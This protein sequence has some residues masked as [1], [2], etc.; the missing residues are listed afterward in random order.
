[1]MRRW[2]C[3]HLLPGKAVAVVQCVR[4][5]KAKLGCARVVTAGALR[6][7]CGIVFVAVS[8]P[9]LEGG[10]GQRQCESSDVEVP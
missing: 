7:V 3:G 10:G 8:C 9:N 4:A 6:T 2:L 1:M 5:W